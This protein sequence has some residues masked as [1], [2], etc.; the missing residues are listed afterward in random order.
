[1]TPTSRRSKGAVLLAKRGETQAEI[2]RKLKVSQP[3]IALWRSSQRTPRLAN[4]KQLLAKYKIPI[5]AWDEP[6][7]APAEWGEASATGQVEML[8]AMAAG[9]RAQITGARDLTVLERVKAGRELVR[10]IDD[11]R[12]LKGGDV[13]EVDL[14]NHPSWLALRTDLLAALAAYPDARAAVISAMERRDAKSAAE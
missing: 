7:D 11:L 4:R 13:V 8:E 10:L 9:V 2:A 12:R 5:E 14:V 3:M 6:P 1:M